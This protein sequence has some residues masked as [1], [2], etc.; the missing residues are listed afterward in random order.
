PPI[1]EMTEAAGTGKE[2]MQPSEYARLEQHTAIWRISVGDDEA[3]IGGALAAG[4]L[5]ATLARAGAAGA[6][7]PALLQLH[8]P[9][10]IE[11]QTMKLNH[12]R[13][14]C[15]LF[16]AAW[17]DGD[18]MMSRGLTAFGHPELE[19]PVDS[20]LNAAYF[21]LMDIASNT[22]AREEA[23]PV[24]ANLEVGGEQYRLE[25]GRRGPED[26]RAAVNGAFGTRSI[27]P[28]T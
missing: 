12:E 6:F 1:E 21:R 10:F 25:E 7:V 27:V 22:I 5:M 9:S 2:P 8:S 28:A 13:A 3:A 23:Y 26:E 15:N 24:G 4:R 19:T 16:V 20:G 17:D 18:W 11:T 14:L